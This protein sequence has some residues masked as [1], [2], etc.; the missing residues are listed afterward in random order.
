MDVDVADADVDVDAGR[1]FAKEVP[2]S[3]HDVTTGSM[4]CHY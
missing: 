4:S 3:K 2:W 1:K